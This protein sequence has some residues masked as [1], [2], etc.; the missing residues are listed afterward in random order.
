MEPQQQQSIPSVPSIYSSA[1]PS[2]APPGQPP[3]SQVPK[4]KLPMVW[5]ISSIGAVAVLV[6]VFFLIKLL[7]L[8]RAAKNKVIELVWWGTELEQGAVAPFLVD[9]EQKHNVKVT[10]VKQDKQDYRD[11]LT[12][13][14]S[15]GSGPDI[16]EIHNTWLPMFSSY[17]ETL[18]Q[19]IMDAN[20]YTNTFYPLVSQDMKASS[21]SYAGIPLFFDGLALFVNTSYLDAA[22]KSAPYDWNE[23]RALAREMSQCE[24]EGKPIACDQYGARLVRGGVAL[25]SSTNVEHWQD[26][27]SLMLLQNG[28]DPASPNEDTLDTLRFFLDFVRTDNV[29]NETLPSSSQ[30]FMRGEVAMYI[31]SADDAYTILR[32]NPGLHFKMV[33]VPQLARTN[34]NLPDITFGSYWVESVSNK[35]KHTK[36]SWEFLQFLSSVEVLPRLEASQK[37]AGGKEFL[38]SRVDLAGT[39]LSDPLLGTLAQEAPS[40]HSS[41]LTAETNDGPSGINTQFSAAY[42]DALA[43][44]DGKTSEEVLANL[45]ASLKQAI[46]AYPQKK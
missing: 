15:K 1:S 27:V 41:Y 34:P 36:E 4:R 3:F 32:T 35:S 10:Y 29:W 7:V 33:P 2:S 40:A 13:S 11:R 31:G 44:V 39:Y 46:A 9:Y 17:V 23:L 22:G 5:I 38:P 16:F 30:A 42:L 26:I 19:T 21:G 12:S 8:D 37:T 25:G 28:Q 20:T 18:P 43:T 45:V 14:L 24:K 6:V